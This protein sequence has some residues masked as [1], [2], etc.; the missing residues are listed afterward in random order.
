MKGLMTNSPGGSIARGLEKEAYVMGT[1]FEDAV[2]MRAGHNG[3][4]AS[5]ASLVYWYGILYATCHIWLT[6][7]HG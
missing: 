6:I 3:A 2:V 1:A 4:S 5:L 7:S